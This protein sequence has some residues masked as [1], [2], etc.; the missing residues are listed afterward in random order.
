[1]EGS[2][3]LDGCLSW[4]TSPGVRLH[5][6]QESRDANL[7]EFHKPFYFTFQNRHRSAKMEE[8]YR[9][10]WPWQLVGSEDLVFQKATW[11]D[12]LRQEAVTFGHG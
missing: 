3:G 11:I 12:L 10:A 4:L 1:M 6:R 2:Q 8:L 5:G 7:L 9:M